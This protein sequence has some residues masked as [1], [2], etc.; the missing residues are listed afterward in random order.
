MAT[1][2][3]ISQEQGVYL[4]CDKQV[5][6]TD[7]GY[8][9]YTVATMIPPVEW[10]RSKTYSTLARLKMYMSATTALLTILHNTNP[11]KIF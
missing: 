7:L 6:L 3:T 10:S 4:D 9:S 5:F 8:T 11:M 2:F 1:K